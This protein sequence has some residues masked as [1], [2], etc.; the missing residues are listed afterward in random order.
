MLKPIAVMTSLACKQKNFNK[1]P[2][3]DCFEYMLSCF[4]PP[5][6]RNRSKDYCFTR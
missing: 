1:D 4:H 3:S 5:H 2:R 6:A